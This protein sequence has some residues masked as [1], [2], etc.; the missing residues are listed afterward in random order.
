MKYGN[1][2]VIFCFSVN[3]QQFHMAHLQGLGQGY[4]LKAKDSKREARKN[5]DHGQ[6]PSF[7]CEDFLLSHFQI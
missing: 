6:H 2:V 5:K 4:V 7:C 3:A 1:S